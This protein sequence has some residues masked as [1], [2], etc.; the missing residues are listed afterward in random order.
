VRHGYIWQ[1]LGR[2]KLV[3]DGMGMVDGWNTH[4]P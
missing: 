1:A 3:W 2:S 4:D